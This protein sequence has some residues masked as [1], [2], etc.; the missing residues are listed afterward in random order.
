MSSEL[1]EE[2]AEIE[3]EFEADTDLGALGDDDE[4]EKFEEEPEEEQP[5]EPHE[6]FVRFTVGVE[7]FTMHVDAVRRIVD[8]ADLTRVPRTPRSIDGIMDLRGDITAVIDPRVLFQLDRSTEVAQEQEVIVFEMGVYG[9]NA[10]IR[11]D[12]VD[13]VDS[14]L[15]SDILLDAADGPSDPTIQAYF[16]NELFAAVVRQEENGEATYRPVLDVESII[17]LSR[18]SVTT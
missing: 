9:G 3:E 5:E 11:I 4:I 13:G 17:D 2:L 1:P 7:T 8:I 14:V 6:K 16:E 12:N 15:Y 10:G 18:Q